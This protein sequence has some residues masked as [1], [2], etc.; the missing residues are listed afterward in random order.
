MHLDDARNLKR[1]LTES[2]VKRMA[3]RITA[4]SLDLRAGPLAAA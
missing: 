1:S 4:R 2:L 3:H